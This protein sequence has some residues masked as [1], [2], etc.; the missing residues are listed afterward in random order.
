MAQAADTTTGSGA[1]FAKF[2]NLG[3]KLLGAFAGGKSRQQINY[4]TKEPV[5]K[6]DGKPA[7]EEV[8]HFVAMPG[9]TAGTGDRE[10]LTTID[11]GEHVRFAVAGFKWGQVIDQ[12][13]QLPEYSGFRA[14][15]ICSGDVYEIELI[16]WSAAVGKE[17]QPATQAQIQA[18][19]NAG[20]TVDEGRIIIRSQ[21]DKDRFVLARSRSGGNTNAAADYQITVRRPTTGEKRW[22]QA[23][24]ELFAQKP[25]ERQPAMAGA[26]DQG[27]GDEEPF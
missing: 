1:P 24:D 21:E 8:M 13:K 12:R 4:T 22:E 16:G 23:A 25:W 20:F 18:A 17:G 15:Q 9:T 19:I 10:A 14:G 11:A 7:L 5:T 2:K 26:P 6:K 27:H 3:D